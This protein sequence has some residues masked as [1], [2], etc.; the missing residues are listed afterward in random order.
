[1]LMLAVAVGP[2]PNLERQVQGLADIN[3]LFLAGNFDKHEVARVAFRGDEIEGLGL[4]V[5]A[6][7]VNR[8][9]RDAKLP[10]RGGRDLIGIG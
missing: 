2:E 6:V 10:L 7:G 3:L 9:R 5:G 4:V 8:D 1:M